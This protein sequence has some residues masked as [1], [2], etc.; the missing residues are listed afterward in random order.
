MEEADAIDVTANLLNVILTE[1]SNHEVEQEAEILVRI[2]GDVLMQLNNVLNELL[3]D[4]SPNKLRIIYSI[5]KL[6][7]TGLKYAYI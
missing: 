3:Q 6:C 4:N 2:Y 1:T 5:G 7:Q